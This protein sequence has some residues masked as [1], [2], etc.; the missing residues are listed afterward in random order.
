MAY[1][2]AKHTSQKYGKDNEGHYHYKDKD[3]KPTA[4]F[5]TTPVKMESAKQEKHN[6]MY[7]NPIAKDASW[8]SK[9]SKSHFSSPLQS[10]GG[11]ERSTSKSKPKKEKGFFDKVKDEVSEVIYDYKG[12]GNM[13]S[14]AYNKA[15][16]TPRGG[17]R[18]IIKD[19]KV[20]YDPNRL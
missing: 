17:Y 4:R 10:R 19:G 11:D 20:N 15:F 18:P 3:G 2:P 13:V 16:P 9:H 5:S 8:M 14:R 7:D 6:L 12:D 1:S